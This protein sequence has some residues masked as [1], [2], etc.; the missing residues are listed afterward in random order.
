LT[1]P[2]II[3]E[4]VLTRRNLNKKGK[5]VGKATLV[6]FLLDFSAPLN[7]ASALSLSNY[8]VLA[9]AK[10]GRKLVSQVIRFQPVYNAATQSVS[11]MLFG[12]QTFLKGGKITVIAAPP[13]GITN[14]SGVFLDGNNEGIPGDNGAFVILPKASGITR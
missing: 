10:K 8:S 5:P 11:L 13:S 6:G 12:N 2:T 4:Q 7:A 1:P 14:T 3:G 9:L